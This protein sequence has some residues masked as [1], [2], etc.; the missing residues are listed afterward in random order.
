[1]LLYQIDM[2]AL[3]LRDLDDAVLTA[4]KERAA[5]NKRSVQGEVK[6]ILEDAVLRGRRSPKRAQKLRLKTVSVG[7]RSS[8]SREDIYND[9]ER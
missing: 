5:R 3:H 7:S 6:T 4:L 1:M 8:Y 9:D 2:P